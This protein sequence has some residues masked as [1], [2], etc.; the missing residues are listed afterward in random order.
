VTN[1]IFLKVLYNIFNEKEMKMD[2]IN[3]VLAAFSVLVGWPAFLTAAINLLKFLKVL[4]DGAADGV[5]FWANVAAFVAVGVAVF[6]GKT[7]ILSWVDASL[8]GLAKILVDILVLLG[9]SMTSMA[10]ARN[11]HAGVRGL[12]VIGTT[13]S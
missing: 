9:G 3:L 1:V 8:V 11:Y 4:P 5:N 7:D 2:I 6:T 10:M 12:P 13:H